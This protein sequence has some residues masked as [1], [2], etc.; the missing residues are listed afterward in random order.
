MKNKSFLKRL[1]FATSGIQGALRTE[2]SF[3]TQV[4]G[5]IFA[6]MVLIVLMPEPLWWGLFAI[7]IG[8]VLALEL[9]NTALESFID[10]VHPA[11]NAGIKKAKD[12]AAGAVLIA[13]A[14]S[15]AVFT[16]FLFTRLP[17]S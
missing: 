11:P 17:T 4:M 3:R 9:V 5:A 7:C 12:C 10:T 13:S 16:A 14:I 8:L 1:G 2:K 6:V 15:I